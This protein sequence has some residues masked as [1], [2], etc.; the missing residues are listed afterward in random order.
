MRLSSLT[1][2]L[3][4]AAISSRAQTV[5]SVGAYSMGQTHEH[6]WIVGSGS[7][8][9]GFEQY[10]QYQDA[11]GRDLY[12]FSDVIAKGV[13]SP[14][15]TTVYCGPLH[16]TV[17]GPAWLTG[18]LVAIGVVSLTLLILAGI[19]RVRRYQTDAHNVA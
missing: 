1:F 5:Y 10:R 7:A 3:L 17:R 8:R 18:S 6:D 12:T 15:Y 2:V 16:F 13:A 19:G 11:S 14:R 9:F 4:V